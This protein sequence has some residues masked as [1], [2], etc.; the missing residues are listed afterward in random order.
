MFG[1]ARESRKALNKQ[2]TKAR[3]L[4]KVKEAL[5]T[6]KEMSHEFMDNKLGQE[7]ESGE[8]EV[9][10]ASLT[11]SISIIQEHDCISRRALYRTFT[12]SSLFLV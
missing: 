12:L 1:Y 10:Q 5:N 4:L 11:Q 9:E 3:A 2:E 8:T 7:T 6:A